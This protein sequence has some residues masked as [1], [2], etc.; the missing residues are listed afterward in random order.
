MGHAH[1]RA[2]PAAA[3]APSPAAPGWL[4]RLRRRRG[5]RRVCGG[6]DPHRPEVPP[7]AVAAARLGQW[8]FCASPIPSESTYVYLES[9]PAS[10]LPAASPLPPPPPPPPPPVRPTA[11]PLG[12]WPFRA[13]S[14]PSESTYVDLQSEPA[15]PLPGRALQTPSPEPAAVSGDGTDAWDGDLLVPPPLGDMSP[16]WRLTS[17]RSMGS[18]RSRDW[19]DPCGSPTQSRD[20]SPSLGSECSRRTAHTPNMPVCA[21][22]MPSRMW[23]PASAQGL[24]PL[25][26]KPH[27]LAHRPAH[28]P[29]RRPAP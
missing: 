25:L 15:S 5:F 10:P 8:P 24:S 9:Q 22:T 28:L 23:G 2:H 21:D 7:P 20:V 13:S 6:A 19:P 14:A 3:P 16:V 18:L 1:S 26:D 17:L 11:V 4:R 29:R 12:R 27:P